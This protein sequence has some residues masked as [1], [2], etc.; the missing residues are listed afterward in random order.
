MITA[1]PLAA[2]AGLDV[3]RKGGNVVDV[4]V[5]TAYALG[6]VEPYGSGI[7]GEGMMLIYN[8]KTRTSTI[9]D[10]KGFSPAEASYQ[11]LDLKNA[12]LWNRT[13]KGASVP[14]AVAGLELAREKFGRLDR[15]TVMQPAIDYALKGFAIDSS[16]AL[17]I[18]SSR[19]ILERDSVLKRLYFPDGAPLSEGAMLR[20]VPYGHSLELI[21]DDGP[22]AFYRGTIARQ[23]A[24]DAKADG[25]FITMADLAAYQPIIRQPLTGEYRGYRIVTTPPPCGGMLLLET[26]NILK[27]FDMRACDAQN[28]Y[29]LHILGETF[30]MVY[31]DE[32]AHNADPA[33]RSVPA[34]IVTSDAYAFRRFT[35]IDLAHARDTSVIRPGSL[36]GRNTTHLNVMDAEGNAVALTITLSSLF[37]TAYVIG[38]TGMVLNN[39][40][41][42]YNVDPTAANSLEPHKRVVTSLVPTI[43]FKDD[44]PVMVTGAPGGD[45]IISGVAQVL[46]NVLDYGMPLP[47]AVSAPRIFTTFY[48]PEMEM[49]KG[50]SDATTKQLEA[51]GYP[52]KTYGGLRAYFAV[53]NSIQYDWS[54]HTLLGVADPRRTGA[55]IG[56]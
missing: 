14:G 39:E 35:E 19:R 21:R 32:A 50:F 15:V 51:L 2:Q 38:S 48:Q 31:K 27:F 41:Q 20:N 6:V 55:A 52:L 54:T 3:H 9:I 12:R 37:G 11:N 56:E 23:I 17:N 26:L 1:N 28:G 16:F 24:N 53:V 46:V 7:G 22:D 10:F 13:I 49:E 44:R 42:N 29:A 25:G 43:V 33:F 4:A 45:L 36:E 40:M 47:E 18:K 34:D 30:K 8:A 5:A